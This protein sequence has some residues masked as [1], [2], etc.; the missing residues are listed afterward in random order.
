MT[1]LAGV[2]VSVTH[3]WSALAAGTDLGDRE[4]G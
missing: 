3:W 4:W 2:P 1:S